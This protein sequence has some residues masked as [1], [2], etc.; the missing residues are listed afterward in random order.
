MG[1]IVIDD[2]LIQ[3]LSAPSG[4]LELCDSG[5]QTVGYFVTPDSFKALVYT[6]A[7]EEFAREERVAP[8]DDSTEGTV[9][10][11][12][13]LADLEELDRRGSGTA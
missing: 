5:G 11:A 9:S 7:K 4:S 8:F 1:K 13:L 12:E 2:A 3:R 10:T 6:W